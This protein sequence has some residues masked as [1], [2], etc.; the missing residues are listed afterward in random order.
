MQSRGARGNGDGVSGFSA[1][2]LPGRG[3]ELAEHQRGGSGGRGFEVLARRGERPLGRRGQRAV[4]IAE[5][6]R[7]PKSRSSTAARLVYGKKP[8]GSTVGP[9]S[10]TTGVP[11]PVAMCIT[12]VSPDTTTAARARQAPVSCSVNSPATL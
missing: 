4:P 5:H 1:Q 10:A 6:G 3:G 2:H 11:T 12:P 7:Q 9:N 8:N